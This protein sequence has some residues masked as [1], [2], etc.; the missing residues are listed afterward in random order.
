MPSGWPWCRAPGGTQLPLPCG[1][2]RRKKRLRPAGRLRW[3]WDHP[4][5]LGGDYNHMDVGQN[6]RPRGPQMWMSS[7]VLTIQLLWYLILTH[8]HMRKAQKLQDDYWGYYRYRRFLFLRKDMEHM[9][10]WR[11]CHEHVLKELCF[12]IFWGST[13]GV[14]QLDRH[15]KA[16][17]GPE[18]QSDD[19]G[20][21]EK[22]E[23]GAGGT[24]RWV[25]IW[26]IKIVSKIILHSL[27]LS[28]LS[29]FGM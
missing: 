14:K 16:P 22:D 9:D 11:I 1:E 15:L 8:T 13:S 3:G 24:P 25:K 4:W 17:L 29:I 23:S 19:A 21:V 20:C 18:T 6:G 28:R 2:P 26:Y 5:C 12:V 7:L 10:M 27:V